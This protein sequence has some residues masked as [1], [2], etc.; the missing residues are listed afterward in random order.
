[1]TSINPAWPKQYNN[2]A[3]RSFSNT[4]VQKCVCNIMNMFL[5]QIMSLSV[6]ILKILEYQH[7]NSPAPA[8]TSHKN[9]T[10]W[11]PK[12]DF[13]HVW[14]RNSVYICH[15]LKKYGDQHHSSKNFKALQHCSR[16]GWF[17]RLKLQYYLQCVCNTDH[18]SIYHDF[19][20]IE[21]N[22]V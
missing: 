4:D 16:L 18:V 2:A 17:V 22:S 12:D 14:N 5:I 15:I 13:L 19:E 9:A 3:E 21:I 1:M 6:I 11:R 7:C 10:S 20:D 8:M